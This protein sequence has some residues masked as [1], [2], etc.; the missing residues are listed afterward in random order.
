[1]AGMRWDIRVTAHF[2]IA[3]AFFA[4]CVMVAPDYL[5]I[6]GALRAICFW[7]GL[8][9]GILFGVAGFVAA[10]R[11]EAIAPRRGHRRRMIG[12][13]G[14]VASGIGLLGFATAYFLP[15]SNVPMSKTPHE[16]ENEP[17]EKLSKSLN[18]TISLLCQN[19][20]RPDSFRQDMPL[21]IQIIGP[22]ISKTN[23]DFNVANTFF[24]QGDKKIQW[25]KYSPLN[26][27]KCTIINYGHSAISAARFE[28]RIEWREVTKTE[29]GIKSG[30]I[31]ATFNVSSPVIEMSPPP[32]QSNYFYMYS[33]APSYVFVIPSDSIWIR[34]VGADEWRMV[35][36]IPPNEPFAGF[37]F[38][39]YERAKDLPI[40]PPPTP[41]PP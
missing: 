32:S 30:G 5:Q 26:M 15:A 35:K 8:V 6:T 36:L 41:E 38:E 19:S 17:P 24:M 7:G 4:V 31:I 28:Y 34:E 21:R 3:A 18:H 22:E 39:P 12:L 1:M 14:M 13:Y 33:R 23:P 25:D 2:F 27:E 11:G 40:A 29:S 10:F 37:I 9:G 20:V 16:R